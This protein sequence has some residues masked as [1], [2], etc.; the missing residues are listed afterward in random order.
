M[1]KIILTIFMVLYLALAVFCQNAS[2]A[3]ET[4]SS[5]DLNLIPPL[6]GIS[7]TIGGSFPLTGT[8]TAS[9]S[10]RIDQFIT[11]LCNNIQKKP[12][13]AAINRLFAKRN[14][15]LKHANGENLTVDLA[16]FQITGDFKFNPYLKNE[17]VII[18]PPL[19]L[20][21]DYI[22]IDGAI[23]VPQTIQ[24]VDGDKLSDAILIAQGINPAYDTVTRARIS[25]LDKTGDTLKAFSVAISENPPLKRGDRITIQS[26]E[27]QR[28]NFRIVIEGEVFHPGF[29]PITK[30]NTTLRNALE[31]AGG[32]K[33]NADLN[34]VRLIRGAN[35]FSTPFINTE[36][37]NLLMLRM[38]TISE[39][40][41]IS[42]F[43]DNQLRLLS[44]NGAIDFTK[45]F[46]DKSS[47]GD[48]IV[49]DGD[50][51]IVPEKSELV[52]V[53]GQ[54]NSPGYI[55]FERGN[56]AQYYIQKAGGVGEQAKNNAYLIKGNTRS[57]FIVG[58]KDSITVEPGDYIWI[59]KKPVRHFEYYLQQ[60]GIVASVV[61]S[62]ATL[63]LLFFQLYKA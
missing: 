38:S 10:E 20:S 27:N 47:E 55:K 23:N 36:V 63:V 43:V 5:E 50:K 37:E 31:K 14:I 21:L 19:N 28:R 12:E 8:F 29:I 56:S 9:P 45:V 51:I 62:M 54:V 17:D 41:S 22:S 34:R 25:R 42:F 35:V 58:K 11:R 44:G 57:W 4:E 6:N 24:Y 52:Y 61:G 39:E 2:S 18:I 48:F 53:F 49:K 16:K 33:K 13:N 59:P 15:I 26:D 60:V 40:D 7:I 30:N 1:Q 3:R 32:F 46:D